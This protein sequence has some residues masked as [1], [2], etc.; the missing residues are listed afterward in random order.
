M[1]LVLLG[2]A[3]FASPATQAATETVSSVTT[4]DVLID[5]RP[6]LLVVSP[7][8]GSKIDTLTNPGTLMLIK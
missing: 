7:A 2:L 4:T 6:Y 8:P 1:L 3:I 5:A